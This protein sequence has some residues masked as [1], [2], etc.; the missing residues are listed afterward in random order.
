VVVPGALAAA[1]SHA[2][3]PKDEENR[4]QNPK[5]MHSEPKTGKKQ[6]Q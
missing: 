1:Q 3:Q 5:K 2:G 4:S 6:Y